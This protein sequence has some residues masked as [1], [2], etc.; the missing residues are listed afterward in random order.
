MTEQDLNGAKIGSGFEQVR[1]EGVPQRVRM[2]RF[3]NAGELSGAAAGQE[4]GLGRDRPSAGSI[5][6]QP[7]G[8]TFGSPVFPEQFEQLRRQ[9]RLPIPAPFALPYPQDTA[10]RVDVGDFKLRDFADAESAAV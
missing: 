1:G 3:G 2:N 5:R 4:D 7:V 9:Q 8:G 10:P 6:E